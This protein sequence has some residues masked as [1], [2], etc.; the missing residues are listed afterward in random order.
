MISNIQTHIQTM[1][2]QTVSLATGVPDCQ[3]SDADWL[4]PVQKRLTATDVGCAGEHS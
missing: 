1:L 3:S 4:L 2:I